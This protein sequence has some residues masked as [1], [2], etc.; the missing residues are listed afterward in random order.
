MVDQ[1]QSLF[2]ALR[3]S[4]KNTSSQNINF[5]YNITRYNAACQSTNIPYTWNYGKSVIR[6]KNAIGQI[7]I[8][9]IFKYCMERNPCLQPKWHTSNLAIYHSIV[10]FMSINKCGHAK[11]DSL[12]LS[13]LQ[14]WHPVVG[15]LLCY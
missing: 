4:T 1:F 2:Q 14:F 13:H 6:S 5:V 15:K 9:G 7:F 11:D 3:I 8:I 10:H 12:R